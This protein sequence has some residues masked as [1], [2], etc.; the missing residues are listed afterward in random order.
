LVI[1][2]KPT[3]LMS[4]NASKS[5]R[6][7]SQGSEFS[8]AESETPGSIAPRARSIWAAEIRAPPRLASLRSGSPNEAGCEGP[9]RSRRQ[10]A[11]M[12]STTLRGSVMTR[13]LRRTTGQ[14]EVVVTQ[15]SLAGVPDV[16]HDHGF[17]TGPIR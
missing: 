14:D 9:L 6:S 4:A 13:P 16:A 8:A 1:F 17:L 11:R 2:A 5:C 15:A 12:P 10:R 3:P 7:G